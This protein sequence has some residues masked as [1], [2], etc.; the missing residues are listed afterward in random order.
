MKTALITSIAAIVLTQAANAGGRAWFRDIG[1]G[2]SPF[3]SSNSPTTSVKSQATTK[4]K[5]APNRAAAKS[6]SRVADQRI[7]KR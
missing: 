2:A 6:K 7:T 1:P 5:A 4:H 3:V